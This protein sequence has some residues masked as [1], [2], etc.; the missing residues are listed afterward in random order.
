M[1]IKINNKFYDFFERINIDQR[2]DSVASSFSLSAK[3]NPNNEDHKN[4]F[5]P[6]SYNKVQ[7]YDNKDVLILTGTI[8]NTSLFSSSIS[9][10]QNV[11]GYSKAGILEDCTIPRSS[12]PLERLNV[13]LKDIASSVIGY[14]D[15]KFIV[16]SSVLKEMDLNYAKTVAQPE[17]SVK[18]FISKLASQ[19]NII[20]GHNEKGDVLFFKPSINKKSKFFFNDQKGITMSLDVN[21]QGMHSNISVIRQPSKE[22]QSLSP[23]DTISNNLVLINRSI[24]R[25]LSSGTETDTKKAADNILADELKNISVKVS[26]DRFIDIKCGDIVEVQNPEIYLYNKTR[27]MVSEISMEET[28]DNEFMILNLVLPETFTGENPKNIFL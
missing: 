8:L 12:Y 23:V 16:D 11:T 5:K 24:V 2:L 15:L 14:F 18:D 27:L 6:L 1:K 17:E 4:I 20:L 10:L 3:F 19:R 13:S 9:E 25:T 28:K 22:N 7:I 21:G 26:I